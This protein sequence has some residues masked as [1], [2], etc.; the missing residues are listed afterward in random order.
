MLKLYY[1]YVYSTIF[2]RYN[3]RCMVETYVIY[4]KLRLYLYLIMVV[5]SPMWMNMAIM[6]AFVVERMSSIFGDWLI[7]AAMHIRL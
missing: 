5:I 2:Y 6:G 4:S 7:Y 3:F 1:N